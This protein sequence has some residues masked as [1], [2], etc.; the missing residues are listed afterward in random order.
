MIMHS[1]DVLGKRKRQ[2][3]PSV[4]LK[5]ALQDLAAVRME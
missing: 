1:E 4:E 2:S 5:D 3:S